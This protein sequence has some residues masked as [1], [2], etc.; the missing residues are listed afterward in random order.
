MRR[1]FPA[2]KLILRI[3]IMTVPSTLALSAAYTFLVEGT[4]LV[5]PD[6]FPTVWANVVWAI[7][8]LLSLVCLWLLSRPASEWHRASGVANRVQH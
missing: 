8:L 4:F 5:H 2:L 3:I 1:I 7:P 6:V